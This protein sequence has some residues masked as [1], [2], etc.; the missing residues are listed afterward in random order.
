MAATLES[1]LA[2]ETDAKYE[3]IVVDNNC[4]DDTVKIAKSYGVQVVS[5]NNP[6]VC[7]ARQAGTE[8]AKGEIIV[9]T[10]AD[11]VFKPNWLATI[12]AKFR[13]N[14]EV[15]AVFGPCRYYN[16]QWW[17]KIYTHILFTGIYAYYLDVGKPFYITATNTAFKKSAWSGY[18]TSMRQGGDELDLLK[19]LSKR[20]EV[21]FVNSNPVYTSARRLKYGLA[22]TVLVSFVYYYLAAYYLNKLFKRTIIGNAPAFREKEE[23]GNFTYMRRGLVIGSLFILMII[24]SV[25][26]LRHDAFAATNNLADRLEQSA[27]AAA[28]KTRI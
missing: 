15:V 10:D 18:D 6:G 2:Q 12:D 28:R 23:L 26:S 1:L 21:Q 22:Y 24:G 7:H 25:S 5:E 16:G 27:R 8:A 17:A 11:T 9:S 14:S 20:G 19:K 4:S 13:K 3:I